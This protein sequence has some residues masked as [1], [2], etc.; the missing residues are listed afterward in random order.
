MSI[1]SDPVLQDI[2]L[3]GMKEGGQYTVTSS[4]AAY[5]EFKAYQWETI[6]TEIWNACRADRLLET[7]SC[8]VAVSGLSNMVLT[9]PSDF[10]SEISLDVYDA[11]D[12][13]RGTAQAGG[14]SISLTLASTFESTNADMIGR[15]LFIIGGSGGGQHRQIIAYDN[16]T[17]LAY[18][19]EAWSVTT[20]ATSN[21]LVGVTKAPLVRRDY[22]RPMP[23]SGRPTT[24]S[25]IGSKLY[26]YPAGDKYYPIILT[27]RANL[28]RLDDAGAVF[29]RHL[30]ERRH[31]WVQGVKTKTMERY[32]DERRMQEKQVWEAMLRQHS[33]QNPVY[34]QLQ[35]SR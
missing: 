34:T 17:K 5:T 24:Y 4:S 27:Y 22:E 9:L 23:P 8:L 6:K 14:L 2:I 20:G 3:Q 21:Y 10:D 28:T 18:L 16:T 30:R 25:R 33:G 13:F 26:V 7:Q 29:T 32:D 19:D 11:D 35:G 1:P 15:Y 31:L 12:S